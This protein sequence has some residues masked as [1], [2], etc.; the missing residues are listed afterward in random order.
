MDSEYPEG[1]VF[2][3]VLVQALNEKGVSIRELSKMTGSTYEY[4]RRLVRGLSLPSKYMARIICEELNL[5]LEKIEQI[6]SKD[7]VRVKYGD[8][9]LADLEKEDSELGA[10][11][12]AWKGLSEE[13]KRVLLRQAN[14]WKN[15]DTAIYASE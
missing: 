1:I 2:A 8:E 14:L 7:Q 5:D 12:S 15:Q 13:H 4:M 3:K 9:M 11:I 10:L 6:I